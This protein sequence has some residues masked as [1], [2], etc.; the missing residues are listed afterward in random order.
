MMTPE[1]DRL[2]RIVWDYHHL[3]QLLGEA[4]VILVQGSH[5][6]RVAERGAELYLEGRAPRIV[7]SGGLGTL[8]RE[9]WDE[10]EADKFARIALERGVPASAILTESQSTNTGENVLFTKRLLAQKGLDPESFILVQKPYMERRTLAT[11]K[12]LWPEKTAVVTSPR[13]DFDAY[14][15]EAIPKEKVVAIMVGDLQRIR[16]YPARGYQIEQ[17]IPDEVWEAYER[18]VE[19]GHTSHLIRD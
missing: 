14:P 12:K 6:L 10:P 4:D 13:I 8:T 5:D 2:A 3:N 16:L 18:L 7:F 15:T 1:E 9:A 19:L 17:E 11:F